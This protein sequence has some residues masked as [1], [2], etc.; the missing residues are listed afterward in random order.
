MENEE[1]EVGDC[2]MLDHGELLLKVKQIFNEQEVVVLE[3]STKEYCMT[4]D[5][6]SARVC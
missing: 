6:F 4:F 5:E 3:G 2:V 1:F